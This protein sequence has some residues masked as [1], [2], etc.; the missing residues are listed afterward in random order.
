MPENVIID[1]TLFA[2]DLRVIAVGVPQFTDALRQQSAAVVHL[3]WQPP[4][5]GDP[6]LVEILKRIYSDSRLMTQIDAAN[7]ETIARI[8][9]SAPEI[10]DVSTAREAMGLPD[11]TISH[12]GPPIEWERMA[13]PQRRAIMGAIQFEGWASNHDEAVALVSSGKIQCYPNHFYNAVA[14][15]TGV[16]SPSMPVLVARNK[17]YGNYAF[18]TLNEGRGNTLWFGVFDEGTLRRLQWMRDELGPALKAT[19]QHHGPLDV[20]DIIA[21]GLQMGDECHA[22]HT[23]CTALLVKRL[24]PS[25]LDAGIPGKTVAEIVRFLDANSHFFLNFTMVGV[26]A[27]MDAAQGVP[28]STIATAM[29]R[30]GV[31]FMLRVGGLGND[32]V[33][34]P[35]S[36]MDEAVYYIGYTVSDAAGDI[37]DSAIIETCG[38]GGMAIA[39]APTVAPFVGGRLANE[40]AT[41]KT[42]SNIT[43]SR[44]NK[45]RIATMDM[46]NTPLGID[47][48]QAVETRI[49]PFITTG[50][51]HETNP[52]VGQIGT[53][54]ARVPIT[55]FDHALIAL[56]RQWKL[57]IETTTSVKSIRF[58][59][60]SVS[61]AS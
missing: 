34:S 9:S 17:T 40:I 19:I 38:L 45:F 3:N 18:S 26:K 14:P 44:H 58:N 41:M 8:Q 61:Y 36:Q 16:I 33:L 12:A 50:V 55:I 28:Y 53:G 57:D 60:I 11:Y 22:R 27:T 31:D 23:A 2:S 42:L 5:D 49:V 24:V 46:E 6:E 13:G 48:R 35:V 52:T 47:V 1:Q 59:P 21:Q 37:G 51:L 56:A 30:N 43:L 29:S 4:A 39:A 32:W 20:F 7:Q 54:V 15:M 25:M 10:I